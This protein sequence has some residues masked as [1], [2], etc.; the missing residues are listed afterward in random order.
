MWHSDWVIAECINLAAAVRPDVG[1]EA[2]GLSYN[3]CRPDTL[4]NFLT[5]H[6]VP[7]AHYKAL[8]AHMLANDDAL[9]TIAS[10]SNS[11][12]MLNS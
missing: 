10:Q 12:L 11:T 7:A 2:M 3:S 4:Q 8:Y 1:G 5:C 6:H 9:R